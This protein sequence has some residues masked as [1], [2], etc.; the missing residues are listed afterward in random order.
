MQEASLPTGYRT[1]VI[2]NARWRVLYP[3]HRPI[4][5]NRWLLAQ[6]AAS[7]AEAGRHPGRRRG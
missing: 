4:A 1:R 7:G 6:L 5:F 2:P 3:E